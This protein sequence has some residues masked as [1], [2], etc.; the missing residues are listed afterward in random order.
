[1]DDKFLHHLKESEFRFNYRD[2]DLFE[3]LIL[4]FLNRKEK[5][6]FFRRRR[7]GGRRL[8]FRRRQR[9]LSRDS[10]QEIGRHFEEMLV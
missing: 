3:V 6:C 8:V 9:P 4:I 1:M 7:E 5:K 2:K 10:G